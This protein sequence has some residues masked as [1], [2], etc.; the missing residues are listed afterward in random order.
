MELI[1]SLHTAYDK[2]T[3]RFWQKHM[4]LLNYPIAAS[5]N[6]TFTWI[7]LHKQVLIDPN[8][9]SGDKNRQL[10]EA[11]S[12]SKSVILDVAQPP[13]FIKCQNSSIKVRQKVWTWVPPLE[14][15]S[16]LSSKKV[17]QKVLIWGR[18]PTLWTKSKKKLFFLVSFSK[19]SHLGKIHMMML[20]NQYPSY[21]KSAFGFGKVQSNPQKSPRLALY[22]FA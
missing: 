13:F 11:I 19:G 22:K 1:S 4:Q 21:N 17:P 18:P 2:S 15:Y 6:H 3:R 7:K 16:N 8:A 10:R 5:Y 14:K 20:T 12:I 9:G